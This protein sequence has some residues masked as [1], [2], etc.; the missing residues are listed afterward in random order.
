MV[1]KQWAEVLAQKVKQ[2]QYTI[3]DALNIAHQTLYETP[4]TLNGIKP[5]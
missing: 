3:D 1:R 5:S 2:G 4:Q